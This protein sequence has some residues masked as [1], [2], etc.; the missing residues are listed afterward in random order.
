MTSSV[1]APEKT[2][3]LRREEALYG[4][5][6][7]PLSLRQ[8]MWVAAVV[9]A[10]LAAL[11][12]IGRRLETFRPGPDY[13]VPYEM[14]NDYWLFERYSRLAASESKTLVVGDSV[15]WGEYVAA[16]ETLSHYLGA[17]AGEK[18]FANLGVDG[19][20]PVA[21]RGLLEWYGGGISNSRV[22]LHFNPLWMASREHDLRAGK[23]FRFNHPELL[24]QFS[25]EIP[26]YKASYADRLAIEAERLLP[27]RP[28]VRHWR[29]ECLGGADLARWTLKNP[30]ANPLVV[31][32]RRGEEDDPARHVNLSWK[33]RGA[34]V[35]DFPWVAL[36]ESL[37]WRAFQDSVE[38]LRRRGDT[39]LVAVGPLNEYMLTPRS[40]DGYHR[41]VS[42]VGQWLRENGVLYFTP[43]VLP[44][45][46]Y[47]DASHPLRE[48]Y[49]M[50]GRELLAS[51]PFSR[52]LQ[53]TAE[54]SV[55]GTDR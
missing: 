46:Y 25:L 48:G 5:V 19:M 18:R 37:Q 55:Q 14:S 21:Q 27:F 39:L 50:L 44:S 10:V 42:E 24:P 6:E 41:V 36:E 32:V 4:S 53:P 40:R 23:E 54:K 29:W 35:Q 22:I 12:V 11:P 9:L 13:R 20:Y 17:P 45:E 47:A 34:T 30:Y 38:M 43:P 3:E 52:L 31:S 2:A 7:M 1:Q 49:A 51:E 16:D 8:W 33:E 26:A 28:W 15:V